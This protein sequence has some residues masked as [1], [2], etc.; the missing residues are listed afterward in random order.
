MVLGARKACCRTDLPILYFIFTAHETAG[1]LCKYRNWRIMSVYC[2]S[3]RLLSAA[4]KA[5]GGY[6]L[7]P[8]FISLDRAEYYDTF[9]NAKKGK[10]VYMSDCIFGRIGLSGM[11]IQLPVQEF[12][13]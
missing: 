6:Y 8:V 13:C 1:L 10:L 3:G 12:H 7:W 11:G 2:N 4:R 9:R 5:E